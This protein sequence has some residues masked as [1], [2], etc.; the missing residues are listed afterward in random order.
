MMI[1][2]LLFYMI[3]LETYLDLSAQLILYLIYMHVQ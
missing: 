1:A 2:N 3:Y